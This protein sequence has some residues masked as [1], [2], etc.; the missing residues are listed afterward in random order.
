M[1]S[2]QRRIAGTRLRPFEQHGHQSRPAES[3]RS[4]PITKRGHSHEYEAGD[5]FSSRGRDRTCGRA[6][7]SRLRCHFATLECGGGPAGPP[8]FQ[9][10]VEERP[11]RASRSMRAVTSFWFGFRSRLRSSSPTVPSGTDRIDTCACSRWRACRAQSVS[12]ARAARAPRAS[13]LHGASCITAD[14]WPLQW[15][16]SFPT[17]TRAASLCRTVSS[18]DRHGRIR[19]VQWPRIDYIVHLGEPRSAPSGAPAI[20][21]VST[22]FGP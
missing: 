2:R 6:V 8:P 18:L 16:A 7:N 1:R 21:A 20:A 11:P 22:S 9:S 5:K 12:T 17:C 3:N 10:L 15:P 13:S 19:A 4:H 14:T